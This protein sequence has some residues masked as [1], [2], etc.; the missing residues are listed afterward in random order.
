MT[1]N[2]RMFVE[3]PSAFHW[4]KKSRFAFPEI[5]ERD[6]PVPFDF[7][8]F[9]VEWFALGKSISFRIF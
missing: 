2:I 7:P 9:S 5:S 1:E 8:E 6:F 3:I 4:A